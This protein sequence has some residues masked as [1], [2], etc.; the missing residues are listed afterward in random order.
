MTGWFFEN[1][2]WASAV[3]I[4]V[5]IVRRPVAYWFGPGPAYALWLLPAARL[6]MPPQSWFAAELPALLPAVDLVPLAGGADSSLP[7]SDSG[8]PWIEA[9]LVL[10]AAGTAAFFVWQWLGYR[11]FLTRLSLSS[12]SLGGHEG[13]PLIESEAVCGPLA[14]GLL[15]R[16]IVVP[17]DF[18]ARYSPEERRLALDH[19]LVHHRRG[20]IWFNHLA[21]LFLGLNWFN[22]IAWAAFRAFRIDQELACDCAVAAAAPAETRADYARALIKSASPRRL[23]AACP[24]NHADQLKRRLKMMKEHRSSRLRL[25]GGAAALTTFAAISLSFGSA[26]LAHPHPDGEEGDGSER[27][28]ERV[29]ILE[30][31]DGEDARGEHARGGHR[32]P[33][34]HFVIRRRGGPGEHARLGDVMG[35]HGC[36]DGRQEIV[37]VNEGDERDRTRVIHCGDGADGASQLQH[38]ERARERMAQDEELSDAHKSRALEAI[39]RAIARLRAQ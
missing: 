24:L 39:D 6:L 26:G 5:L 23:I 3:L 13:V 7:A 22:P 10:W 31:R 11:Q 30:T 36:R 20:D 1:L 18:E 14:L 37:D 25:F 34:E 4:L 38:L 21:L 15:D 19:E 8:L 9:A 27:R 28:R 35:P 17:A 29:V 16:R 32:G 12:R 33:A 2:G